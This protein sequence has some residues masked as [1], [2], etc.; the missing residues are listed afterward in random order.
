MDEGLHIT[1][2]ELLDAIEWHMNNALASLATQNPERAILGL[3]SAGNARYTAE[4]AL[5][6][7]DE[8]H[9]TDVQKFRAARSRASDLI[10]SYREDFHMTLNVQPNV[11]PAVE[12]VTKEPPAVKPGPYREYHPKI[13]E[14]RKNEIMALLAEGNPPDKLVKEWLEEI[15]GVYHVGYSTVANWYYELKNQ[16]KK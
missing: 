16:K 13:D 3:L 5:A 11:K 8:L 2:A 4:L 7:M 6:H 12:H 10:R 1:V 15:V 14:E 9:G